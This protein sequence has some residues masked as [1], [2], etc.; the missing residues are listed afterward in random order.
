MQDF[1]HQPYECFYGCERLSRFRD[2]KDSSVEFRQWRVG[3]CSLRLEGSA[4]E[5][6]FK[7]FRG[8]GFRLRG[9][10]V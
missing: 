5:L 9:L 4:S 10:G 3:A 7:L 6:G 2:F 8:L 1:V